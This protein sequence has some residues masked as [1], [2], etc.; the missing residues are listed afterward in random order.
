MGSE[1]QHDRHVGAGSFKA[2]LLFADPALQIF[3]DFWLDGIGSL[4][5]Q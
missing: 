4:G 1:R 5:N 2:L 3:L